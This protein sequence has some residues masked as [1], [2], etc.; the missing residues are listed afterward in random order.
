MA[1]FTELEPL[2]VLEK[3]HFVTLLV[4]SS[5][6]IRLYNWIMY[7]ADFMT[8]DLGTLCEV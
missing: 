1:H 8:K 4:V 7:M 3:S 2:R 6:G 5:C